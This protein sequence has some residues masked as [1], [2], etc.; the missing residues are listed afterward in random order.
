MNSKKY[1]LTFVYLLLFAVCY[2]FVSCRDPQGNTGE[3]ET[4][5]RRLII[6]HN[7]G[8]YSNSFQLTLRAPEGATIYY[9]IDGSIPLPSKVKSGGPVF[10][11]SAPIAVPNSSPIFLATRANSEQF[12]MKPGDPR[13]SAPEIYYPTSAQ[14]PKTT[15]I[16]ALMVDAQGKQSEVLT[17]TYFIG[18]DLQRYGNHPVISI[19]TDPEN[20]L[21]ETNGIYVRGNSNNV[22]PNYNF[23]KKGRDW[24]REANLDFYDGNRKMAFTSGVGIR[25]RG[26]WSRDRGQKSFNLYFRDEYPG[27]NNLSNYLLIPGAVKAYPDQT[28]ITRYKNFMLRNGGNDTEMT[29]FYDVFVQSLV[30]DRNFTTQAAVPCIVY[31]NGEYW[32]HYNLQEKYSDHY[33]EQKFDVP[34]SNVIS[35]ETGELDEGVESDMQFYYALMSFK[36]RDL[37]TSE[38]YDEFCEVMDIQSYIDY[39]AAEIYVYNEDWPQNNFQLWRVRN[40]DPNNPYGDT[41]WRWMMYDTEFS[42]GIYNSGG[43]TGQSGKDPFDR[44][45]NGEHKDHDNNLLFKKLLANSDFR[46]QFVLTMMDMYN[47]NFEYNSVSAKLDQ[48]AA[49]YRPLIAQYYERWGNSWSPFEYKVSD[50]RNYLRNIR[51]AMTNVYLPSHFSGLG[52]LV[53]VTLSAKENGSNVPNAS[54]K[55]NTTTPILK[56][57]SWT[58]KYYTGY[59][60]TVTANVPNGYTFTGWTVSGGSAVTPSAQTT[61]VNL[62]GNAVITA[63][64]YLPNGI[65]LSGNLTLPTIAE[66]VQYVNIILHNADWSWKGE[67]FVQTTGTSTAWTTRIAPFA[68]ST[69]IFFQVEGYAAENDIRPLFVI[70]T[71]VSRNVQSLSINNIN[72]DLSNASILLPS[73]PL[74]ILYSYTYNN[75]PAVVS[76]DNQ[77]GEYKVTVSTLGVNHWD[78]ALGLVYGGEAGTRYRYS[79]YAKTETG[80]RNMYVQCYWDDINNSFGQNITMTNTYQLFTFE[81]VLPATLY[82]LPNLSF[83]CADQLG[84]F[85]VKDVSIVQY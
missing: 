57:G 21:D 12:Y 14:V 84:I 67:V 52:N 74:E 78:A 10:R 53:D 79:F 63:N 31:L 61:Q 82:E 45:L 65:T 5:S 48:I 33:L 42:M 54:I 55:I 24:E 29:K 56:G 51:D 34:R 75:D 36:D 40:P 1:Y 81:S 72:I 39:Y 58:G 25:I 19:V 37:S 28:P 11:Y 64:Y 73:D 60:V 71:E 50:A 80:T 22:W 32:G 16:R 66:S 17:R 6:S 27:M 38:N 4:G 18:N 49:I 8:L 70:D 44:I 13:G 77:G 3:E 62:S 15:V 68:S 9:S 43:V 76:M 23:N 2:V 69:P 35:I 47:V 41:K 30:S 7:S 85:Y 26:G 59:P 46:K 20:L 83:Q